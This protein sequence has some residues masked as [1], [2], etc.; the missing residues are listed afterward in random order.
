M[1]RPGQACR[2][3]LRAYPQS[4]RHHPPALL[5]IDCS[6]RRRRQRSPAR[7]FGPRCAQVRQKRRDLAYHG[8]RK[9]R[10]RSPAFRWRWRMRCALALG[11]LAR[12]CCCRQTRSSALRL[13]LRCLRRRS[14]QRAQQLRRQAFVPRLGAAENPGARLRT[15]KVPRRDRIQLEH[16]RQRTHGG[17]V[18]PGRNIGHPAP[19]MRLFAWVHTHNQRPSIC[20]LPAGAH[21][22]RPPGP[23]GSSRTHC[24]CRRGRRGHSPRR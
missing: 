3:R 20:P 22:I 16:L 21:R 24:L 10:S 7:C 17:V 18:G 4:A 6:R 1:E 14:F 2:H 23:R 19:A 5:L 11:R 13:R 9:P 15:Q 8:R 12:W